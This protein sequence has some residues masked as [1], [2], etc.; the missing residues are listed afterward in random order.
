MADPLSIP[1]PTMLQQSESLTPVSCGTI[2]HKNTSHVT[3]GHQ[4]SKASYVHDKLADLSTEISRDEVRFDP[5]GET[6]S[7]SLGVLHVSNDIKTIQ[8]VVTTNPTATTVSSIERE[9][10]RVHNLTLDGSI[11][12]DS[13]DASLYLSANK[14]F[15]FRYVESDGLH[16]SSRLVLEGLDESTGD[17]VPKVEFSSD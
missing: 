6:A 13:D 11:S 7:I 9:T 16:Q 5:K 8:S 14:V 15:R 1:F 3:V 4:V 2:V 10:E 12:W 17:Y